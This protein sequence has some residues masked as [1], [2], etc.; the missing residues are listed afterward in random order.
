MK[1]KTVKALAMM[2][3][4]CMLGNSAASAA[5]FSSD[6]FSAGEA[7]VQTIP[8]TNPSADTGNSV[9]AASA[10]QQ[11]GTDEISDDGST[12]A[13][14]TQEEENPF[15]D[16]DQQEEFSDATETEEIPEAE[17]PGSIDATLSARYKNAVVEAQIEA[18]P[19]VK[20]NCKVYDAANLE[21]QDYSTFGTRVASYLTTSPDGNITRVQ[22]D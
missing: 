12:E 20:T 16:A 3:T 7:A 4:M 1:N 14:S 19:T 13:F 18:D 6:T 10:V 9:D 2:M 8:E 17:D 5:E 21:C 22:F 11:N 15:S